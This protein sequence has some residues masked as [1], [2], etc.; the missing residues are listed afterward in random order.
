MELLNK[1]DFISKSKM[2]EP[3]KEDEVKDLI[4]IGEEMIKLCVE[5]GGFGL[6]APQVGIYKSMFVWM[7]SDDSFQIV[8]NPTYYPDGK[9]TNVVEGCLSFPGESYYLQRL[10]E[11]RA[12]YY[13]YD[14]EKLVK[15]TK[16]LVGQ[17]AFVFQH[18]AQHLSNIKIADIGVLL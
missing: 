14:G 10:K 5:K 13:T 2:C 4:Q 3:V 17:K 9:K 15:N 1:E 16:H 7:I 18:E 12:V 6:A 8:F 11:I